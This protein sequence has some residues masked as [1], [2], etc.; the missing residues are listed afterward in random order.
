MITDDDD[1]ETVTRVMFGDPFGNRG[2][3]SKGFF[4]RGRRRYLHEDNR[5]IMMPPPGF[6]TRRQARNNLKLK[7]HEVHLVQMEFNKKVGD[8]DESIVTKAMEKK[9]Q[10][11]KQKKAIMVIRKV[12]TIP[13]DWIEKNEAGCRF[14]VHI[15]T[16]MATSENPV[17]KSD[18]DESTSS[19]TY[20]SSEFVE[21]TGSTVYDNREYVSFMDTLDSMM[22]KSA[23]KSHIK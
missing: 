14:W 15:H 11:V 20:E 2:D 21:A 19:S 22:M 1:A 7:N 4:Y 8:T 3:Y 6:M 5:D 12:P 17:R 10:D 18:L 16:G 9:K 23:T 13:S